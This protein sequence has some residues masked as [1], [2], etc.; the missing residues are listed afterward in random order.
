MLGI[1]NDDEQTKNF[2]KYAISSSSRVITLRDLSKFGVPFQFEWTEENKNNGY[3]YKPFIN[4]KEEKI[5]KPGD[6]QYKINLYNFRE[7][8]NFNSKQ[9]KIGFFGC[10]F[11]FGEGIE[12]E[13][14]FVK[15]ASK[16]LD[17]NPFNFGIGGSSIQRIART[18][19]AALKVIAL[20]CIVVTLPHWSRQMY[21]DSHGKIINLIPYWPHSSFTDINNQLLKVKEDYY[22]VQ[23]ISFI[24]WIYDLAIERNIKLVLS[25]WDSELNKL[26]KNL[27]PNLTID[28]FP[29]I[30]DKCA[31]DK[32]HPG[33]KSHKAHAEQI[34]NKVNEFT[35]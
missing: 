21:V 31:R 26:C 35:F 5:V 27:Y 14:T 29:I 28:T 16:E 22:I 15:I 11:T 34:V 19:S 25:S 3:M 24:S 1:F 8:W 30:D 33:E 12:Y 10:S 7:P 2:T 32:M 23:S 9:K 4:L 17:M 6:W 20:D 13:N 18:F